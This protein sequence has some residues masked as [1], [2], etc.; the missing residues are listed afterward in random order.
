[1]S[2][3]FSQFQRQIAQA[4]SLVEG[5][6][7]LKDQQLPQ[8]SG[9]ELVDTQSLLNRCEDICEKHS[10]KKPT[11]RIIH[12]LACSGG[13]ALAQYIATMPNVY[14]LNE[15]HPFIRSNINQAS[16]E[17]TNVIKDDHLPKSKELNKQ[18]FLENIKSIYQHVSQL[19]LDLVIRDNAYYD[20][21]FEEHIHRETIATLLAQDFNIISVVLYRDTIDTFA[22][23]ASAE[24]FRNKALSFNEY[25]DRSQ[26]FVTDYSSAKLVRYEDLSGEPERTI[27]TICEHLQIGFDNSFE[28]MTT[29]INH[30]QFDKWNPSE[31][32]CYNTKLKT[33]PSLEEVGE[34][35]SYFELQ[36][37]LKPKDKKLILIATMPR[38]GSTWLF[39]C[40]R[41]IHKIQKLDFY[42]C[43][44]DD[45]K[46]SNSADIHIVKVHNPEHRLSSQSDVIISSR[47]DIRNICA[48]LMRM[49]WLPE[50]SCKIIRRLNFLVNSLHPFWGGRSVLE[51]EYED[52]AHSAI[53]VVKEIAKAIGSDLSSVALAELVQV[54]EQLS[55]PKS[56]DK[57]TQL[58]PHHRALKETDFTTSLDENIQSEILNEFSGWLKK[59]N[60]L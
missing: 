41:E 45:Y 11:I 24:F 6:A 4:L 60:Y 28:L 8:L 38:S 53:D 3:S 27:K 55:N 44:I 30:P 22:S 5:A 31:T 37:L 47:R 12:H 58:H 2:N 23:L 57:V 56:F 1:M 40:V 49:D 20:Y 51:L 15:V 29:E 54:L 16:L 10:D 7:V 14:V 42:S 19:G 39:N 36:K 32:D 25:C 34:S 35:E 17:L 43:W 50:E 48:S 52:I 9:K 13:A 26:A 21:L 33:A 46:P 59:F 18:L